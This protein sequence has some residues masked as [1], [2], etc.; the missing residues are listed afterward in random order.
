[1]LLY[2]EQRGLT[3]STTHLSC[4]VHDVWCAESAAVLADMWQLGLKQ[5]Q[6]RCFEISSSTYVN[7]RPL[8]FAAPDQQVLSDVKFTPLPS[9]QLHWLSL[10]N[11][12][13]ANAIAIQTGLQRK[14]KDAYKVAKQMQR[15]VDD[16]LQLVQTQREQGQQIMD[17]FVTPTMQ[18]AESLVS[19]STMQQKNVAAQ[20]LLQLQNMLL[21]LGSLGQLPILCALMPKVACLQSLLRP[22][23]RLQS[24]EE[25]YFHLLA[26][27]GAYA[28]LSGDV[29]ALQRMLHFIHT[30]EMALDPQGVEL[31]QQQQGSDVKHQ[32][33]HQQHNDVKQPQQGSGM[34]KQKFQALGSA[35]CFSGAIAFAAWTRKVRS[36]GCAPYLRYMHLYNILTT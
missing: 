30:P 35:F 21:L 12:I 5:L 15:V 36:D 16:P 29:Q 14:H 23:L 18:T 10:G 3:G 9:S 28:A 17:W 4:L 19:C 8:H 32:H 6:T 11:I 1:M 24:A 2:L 33:H 31:Q 20:V 27:F 25:G 22:H 34:Q 26:A 7:K 13:L